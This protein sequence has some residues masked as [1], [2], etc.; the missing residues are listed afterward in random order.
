MYIA[1]IHM[2][3][4]GFTTWSKGGEETILRNF[5]FFVSRNCNLLQ[6][7][8]KPLDNY[9][10]ALCCPQSLI[11]WYRF[12]PKTKKK[13]K[14]LEHQKKSRMCQCTRKTI[15]KTISNVLNFLGVVLGVSRHC[16]PPQLMNLVG[17]PHPSTEPIFTRHV[18]GDIHL[19]VKSLL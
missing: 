8:D 19:K 4:V 9:L 13:G 16:R 12:D 15:G 7:D 1:H 17:C 10:G 6:H 14:E 3:I 5:F 18:L 11:K 2:C